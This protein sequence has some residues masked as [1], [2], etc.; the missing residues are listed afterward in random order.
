MT[1][2]EGIR[3]VVELG[4][5]NSPRFHPNLDCRKLDNVDIVADFEKPLPLLSDEYEIVLSKFVIE[6]IG[7]RYVKQFVQELYRIL[8]PN[9]QAIIITANLL[10]Q[11]KVIVSKQVWDGNESNLI[12]GGQDHEGNYHKNGMSPEYAIRLFKE[13]GFGKVEVTP[14]PNC[15][16]DMVIKG[17][18]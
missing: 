15:A 12:F 11:A 8:K 10:E 4:G 17:V 5:G 16:T 2:M 9:G 18:K 6:H 3:R 14:L 7:W 1:N 13:V